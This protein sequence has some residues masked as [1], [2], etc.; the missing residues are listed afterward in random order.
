M[1]KKSFVLYFDAYNSLAALPAEQRGELLLA[2]FEYAQMAAEGRLDQ[3]A[4]L[5]RHPDLSGEARIAFSF[6]ARTICRDTQQWLEK[7]ARYARAARERVEKQRQSGGR[8]DAWSYVED[9]RQTP[10]EPGA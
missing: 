2:L 5:S 4:V 7:R 6:L 9:G 10:G 8:E 1:E 3:S